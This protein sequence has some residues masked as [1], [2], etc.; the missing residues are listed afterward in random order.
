M[1]KK[2]IL[3]S[4]ITAVILFLA[5][6]FIVYKALFGKV[7][8][9]E[10]VKY[11]Y[12]PTGSSYNSVLD[13][14]YSNLDIKKP[15][16]FEWVAVKKKY[17]ELI[18][19]GRYAIDSDIS[20]VGLVNLLRSGRQ[21]PV[22]VTFNNVRSLNQ[23][24]GKIGRQI[25][26]DSAQLV[27]YFSKESNF[28]K[29]GFKSENIIALFIPD[30]YEFYWNTDPMEF[31]E[32]M[33]KEYRKFWNEERLSKAKEKNLSPVEVAILASIIDDEVAKKDEKPRIAGVYLN[34]LKR[35]I[36][37]QACPTIKFALNDFTITRVLK[38]HLI[39]DSPYNTY[40]HNGFPPGPIGCPSKDGLDAVLNAEKHD[41]LF[42]AAK[43]DFSGY[44]NFSRTL[45]EHNRYAAL[46]QKELNRRKIFK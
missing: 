26:T 22:K 35:G 2:I 31:Y 7:I 4:L 44:H 39:V 42:F 38:K 30:T 17:P 13:T 27:S 25:E 34:R 14:L 8:H 36:P 40:R 28:A 21:E 23:I 6:G 20:Y 41:Y 1:N 15:K 29:D 46:Y 43:A 16:L 11:L 19:P 33:L 9:S 37:L 24:A 5:A 12:I 3:F 10:N 32:R 45:S 18:K